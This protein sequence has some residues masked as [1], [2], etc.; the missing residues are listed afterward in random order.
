ML[1]KVKI[2]GICVT[3]SLRSVRIQRQSL[4]TTEQGLDCVLLSSLQKGQT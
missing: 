4:E 3:I 1:L 2:F